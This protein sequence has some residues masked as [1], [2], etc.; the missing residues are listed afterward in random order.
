MSLRWARRS[1]CAQLCALTVAHGASGVGIH[2]ET[3][4]EEVEQNPQ[5]N[6]EPCLSP[7][8]KWAI[9]TPTL[10]QVQSTK[11]YKSLGSRGHG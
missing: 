10:T 3:R 5:E 4:L 6:P 9:K 7:Q 8:R 2:P 1:V 11:K